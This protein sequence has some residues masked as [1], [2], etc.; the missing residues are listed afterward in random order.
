MEKMNKRQK[1][2]CSQLMEFAGLRNKKLAITILKDVKWNVQQAVDVYFTNY[3]GQDIS[4]D[5][6]PQEE[7]IPVD[8]DAL[9]EVFEKYSKGSREIS[10]DGMVAF[11]QDLGVDPMDPVTLVISYQ[12]SAETMGEYTFSE[13]KK[14]FES[15][16]CASVSDLKGKCNKLR[17]L[18]Q[19]QYEFPKIYKYVFD[20]LKEDMAKNVS[21]DYAIQMWKLLLKERYGSDVDE[22]LDKWVEFME[23]ER[24]DKGVK[25][26]TKDQWNSLLD[27]FKY[28]GMTLDK[29]VA[30][31]DDCWPI[32]FD[33]FF[34][35]LQG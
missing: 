2:A 20:F 29:M 15:V 23:K 21:I 4:D 12:M 6:P 16:G 9:K 11:F 34:E 14:G 27:L 3:A 33:N 22:F 19:D 35:Y 10:S 24:D 17:K 18:L 1:D 7:V 30:S 32:L 26:V 28:K 8:S 31:E 25:G 5:E 13:F